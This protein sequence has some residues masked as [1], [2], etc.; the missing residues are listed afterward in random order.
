MSFRLKTILGIACIEA[1]LLLVLLLNS[2]SYLRESNLDALRRQAGTAATLLATASRDAVLSSDLTRLEELVR[3]FL[4]NPGVVYVRIRDREKVLAQG[5]DGALLARP[6]APD[7]DFADLADGVYDV[8]DT[9][10]AGGEEFGRVEL[11]LSPAAI[12]V[13]LIEARNRILG[14]AGLEI[15]LVALF[16]WLLGSYLTRQLRDLQR[17]SEAV[18]QGEVAPHLPVRGRDELAGVVQAFNAMSAR[19]GEAQRRQRE[20][21]AEAQRRGERLQAVVDSE[22]DGIIAIDTQ[23]AITLFSRA[24]E[25]IF[26]YQA[27]EIL[28]RNVKLLIPEPFQSEHDG[29][30]QHYLATGERHIIG[31]GR[32]VIGLRKDGSTFPMDLSVTELLSDE[33]HGFIGLVRDRSERRRLEERSQRDEIRYRSLLRTATDGIHILDSQGRLIEASESFYR[34]LGYPPGT[35]LHVSDWDRQW[36]PEELRLIL[37]ELLHRPMV[38]ET[39]HQRSDGRIIDVEINAHGVTIGEEIMLFASARDISKRK[40][41]EAEL[42][43]AREQ[44]EQASRAKSQFLAVMSHEMRTPLNALLGVQELLLDTPLD[45]KQRQHLQVAQEAGNALTALIGDIL[46]L[47]KVEAGKLELESLPVQ[48]AAVLAEVLHLLQGR[49]EEKGLR[50]SSYLMPDLPAWV[51]GDPTRLRQVLL[52]LVGNAVKFTG[53]G[54]VAVRVA[55]AKAP[56]HGL[57]LFDVTDTGVGIAENVQPHLFN[58]FTQVD[59]SDTRKYGG[60]GLGLA[61]S[62]RLVELWGGR[63]GLESRPG[64]GSRFWFTFGAVCDGAALPDSPAVEEAALGAAGGASVLLVEDGPANQLVLSAMLRHG[65]YRVDVADGGHAAIDAVGAKPYDLILMDVSM[66]DMNG[67]E[68]TRRIRRLGGWAADVPIVA[69]TAHAVKGYRDEC[70][71]AGMNDYA[72]KPIGK[73]DLRALVARWSAGRAGPIDLAPPPVEPHAS[74]LVDASVIRQVAA[75]AGIEDVAGLAGMFI[76]ELAQRHAAIAQAVVGQDMNSLGLESHS[77][78]SAAATFGALPLQTLATAMDKAC[79]QHDMP[80]AL[81][82]A[83]QLLPCAE[84]TLAEMRRLFADCAN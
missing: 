51:M 58:L 76:T 6:F 14:L 84:A 44:A 43:Q 78:K 4:R 29:Y 24:A 11:G 28:G 49:A 77:L 1:V 72:T 55:L 47:T 26:G 38:F 45:E 63:I 50:L 59:P 62:K 57:L 18:A 39:R 69:M 66:P 5:G 35:P 46:D 33:E 20:A 53:Q 74:V 36:N 73:K 65:G 15:G 61:I 82:A 67:M 54:G 71:A 9:I 17:A 13:V 64:E 7:S 8:A 70:L 56:V 23:G 52:N 10:R 16:S 48:P 41:A 32:E 75:D 79:K 40:R 81:A 42:L 22:L 3:D 34:M 60:S 31:I 80:A 12:E 30:L 68:A 83:G 27:G 21:L 19:V 2:L 25:R 37:H